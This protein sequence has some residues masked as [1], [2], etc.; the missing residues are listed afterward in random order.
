VTLFGAAVKAAVVGNGVEVVKGAAQGYPG[1]T[2]TPLIK[3]LSLA[4]QELKA[5]MLLILHRQLPSA[6]DLINLALAGFAH[7][8]SNRNFRA[9]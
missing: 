7:R 8:E 5:L 3:I 1:I 6:H 2:A 9:P 4:K